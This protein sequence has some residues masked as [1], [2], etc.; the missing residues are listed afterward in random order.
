MA[1]L[2]ADSFNSY[3]AGN[4]NTGGN[5]SAMD[6]IVRGGYAVPYELVGTAR[7]AAGVLYNGGKL[8]NGNSARICWQ[9]QNSTALAATPLE[10]AVALKRDFSF[11][12]ER[13]IC[14]SSQI[15]LT[16]TSAPATVVSKIPLLQFGP[17]TV[18]VSNA[19]VMPGSISVY[20]VFANDSGQI[21]QVD[22][23]SYVALDIEI[24]RQ[25]KKL[26][27][28]LSNLMVWEADS[29][30]FTTTGFEFIGLL[31][32]PNL[33][34]YTVHIGRLDLD[35]IVI[36]DGSGT[37]NNER[38]SS[39]T[40]KTFAANQMVENGFYN[41]GSGT[42][43]YD[44]ISNTFRENNNLDS[45][46]RFA[47]LVGKRDLVNVN[48]VGE[49]SPLAVSVTT[50]SRGEESDSMPAKLAYKFDTDPVAYKPPF[51][52]AGAWRQEK[53]ILNEVPG[54]AVWTNPLVPK[55]AWGYEV[56]PVSETVPLVNGGFEYLVFGAVD[57]F[58]VYRGDPDPTYVNPVRPE[59]QLPLATIEDSGPG[60]KTLKGGTKQLGYFGTVANT[61]M[62][63]QQSLP[64]RFPLVEG[65]EINAAPEWLKFINGTQVLFIAKTPIRRDIS[66][67]SLYQA[68]L[69]YGAADNGLSPLPAG[70]PV[71][72]LHIVKSGGFKY[73]IRLM[74]GADTNPS[75]GAYNNSDPVGFKNS[76]WSRLLLRCSNAD[77]TATFWERFTDVELGRHDGIRTILTL[78]LETHP[79]SPIHRVSR[80]YPDVTGI[81]A[82]DGTTA[83]TGAIVVAW[84]PV[85][86]YIGVDEDYV[87][88]VETSTLVWDS[89]G[90]GIAGN[91]PASTGPIKRSASTNRVYLTTTPLTYLTPALEIKTLPAPAF[92][93]AGPPLAALTDSVIV[94]GR[95]YN[96]AYKISSN[97]GQSWESFNPPTGASNAGE[98]FMFKG[99]AYVKHNSTGSV[100]TL[101]KF[102]DLNMVWQTATDSVVNFPY[103][104]AGNSFDVNENVI[105]SASGSSS[106]KDLYISWNGT[107]FAAYPVGNTYSGATIMYVGFNTFMVADQLSGIPKFIYVP[108]TQGTPTNI[109]TIPAA[110]IGVMQFSKK[111]V[112]LTK[113]SM[114][115]LVKPKRLDDFNATLTEAQAHFA[116]IQMALLQTPVSTTAAAWFTPWYAQNK[117]LLGTGATM[118]LWGDL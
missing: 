99:A 82:S 118:Q 10:G 31:R 78:C 22:S 25:D 104:M 115:V 11:H 9:T 32:T 38:V 90:K 57:L 35:S 21:G 66:W 106:H 29:D 28:W 50:I 117:L 1:I 87:P 80:G 103:L 5:V 81:A 55:F 36:I 111:L 13:F 39:L 44:R 12:W 96:G 51:P 67:Q 101:R 47:S 97:G 4:E 109:G 46:F 8:N 105:V 93:D 89:T 41:N 91:I 63:P 70:T 114:F 40:A 76:E 94:A 113:N 6:G 27:V 24:N 52:H 79:Y 16:K 112:V 26:R 43:D 20:K 95:S 64:A 108:P 3:F 42:N 19:V 68:G 116:D 56:A 14:L 74:R 85:L 54:G 83:P 7:W 48:S 30:Y 58:D 65:T 75:N 15:K 72:Q 92:T 73:R 100:S 18:Y 62:F 49:S 110:N 84:R 77:P 59:Y 33:D 61:L 88:P 107:T 86:E 17:V 98:A 69:V 34:N 2:F 23:G 45:R 71:N 37:K 60:A 102:V 53:V